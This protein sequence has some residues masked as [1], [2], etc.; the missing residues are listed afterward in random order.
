MPT[1]NQKVGVRL[2]SRLSFIMAG[3]F[4]ENDIGEALMRKAFDVNP[5]PLTHQGTPEVYPGV[6]LF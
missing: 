5:G 6:F 4:E 1:S 2:S 3:W